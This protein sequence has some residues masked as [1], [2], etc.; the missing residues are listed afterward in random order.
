MG[1]RGR[2]GKQRVID[3]FQPEDWFKFFKY[4]SKQRGL[5]VL[6]PESLIRRGFGKLLE[7]FDNLYLV[8][9]ITEYLFEAEDS[10][11]HVVG[12]TE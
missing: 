9:L 6:T 5:E 8:V 3:G 11:I 10:F 12:A 2:M 4:L 7:G 1:R